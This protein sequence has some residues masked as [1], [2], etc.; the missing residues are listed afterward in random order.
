MRSIDSISD[1]FKASNLKSFWIDA[2]LIA[3]SIRFCEFLPI[4]DNFSNQ[5]T[6]INGGQPYFYDPTIDDVNSKKYG[7]SNFVIIV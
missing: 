1:S 4:N 6:E 5:T 7:E 2:F 3:I